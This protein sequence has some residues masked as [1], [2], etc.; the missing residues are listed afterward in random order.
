MTG[1][2][3]SGSRVGL[4]AFS[5]GLVVAPFLV[6]FF[7][8]G[9]VCR[10]LGDTPAVWVTG[11]TVSGFCPECPRWV[12]GSCFFFPL[13]LPPPLL[14]HSPTYFLPPLPFLWPPL[15]SFTFS[16]GLREV[17]RLGDTPAVWVTGRT[18]LGF[19]P[20]CP[21]WGCFFFLP[22]SYLLPPTLLLAVFV[23]R[24]RGWGGLVGGGYGWRTRWRG[25]RR[26]PDRRADIGRH[27][28]GPRRSLAPRCGRA[29]E[30]CRSAVTRSPVNNG[31]Y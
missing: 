4:R 25:R 23:F 24:R 26:S 6:P 11:R 16:L 19:C 21:R 20:E 15:T 2:P 9:G 28:D 17:S 30:T 3:R 18:S 5:C 13:L 27:G 14:L 29:P 1:V 12:L 31:C 22:S 10:V 7:C 8:F